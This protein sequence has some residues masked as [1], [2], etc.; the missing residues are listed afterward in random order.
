MANTL[1]SYSV[2]NDTEHFINIS[3]ENGNEVA[4]G[5]DTVF[6]GGQTRKYTAIVPA[7]L[8]AGYYTFS[9]HRTSNN[10]LRSQ[11][12]F[13]WDGSNIV[14]TEAT[15]LDSAAVQLAVGDALAAY[16]AATGA[17]VAD[18]QLAILNAITALSIPTVTAIA[19]AVEAALLDDGD[20]QAFREGF[21]ATIEAALSNEADGN[22]TI[23]AFQGAVTA[24]LNLYG[25]AT[26]AELTTCCDEVKADIAALENVSLSDIQTALELVVEQYD[27]VVPSDL[28]NV[29]TAILAGVTG[30]AGLTPAQ[31]T[32]LTTVRDLLEADEIYTAE[33]GIGTVQKFIKGSATLLLDKTV[34]TSTPCD[35]ATTIKEVT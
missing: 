17:N 25:G 32:I 31:S 6:G 34:E 16:G 11:G 4:A 24:A 15:E 33:N 12:E 20:G 19:T 35:I 10:A 22:A 29:Q 7:T 30:S 1:T 23:A 3:D 2:N 26:S 18:A 8:A 5:I 14:H 9:M 27:A 28:A 21:A 13:Y